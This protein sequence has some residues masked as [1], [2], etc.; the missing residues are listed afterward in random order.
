MSKKY[1]DLSLILTVCFPQA[2]LSIS[3][4]KIYVLEILDLGIFFS[5][6]LFDT[7]LIANSF[8]FIVK[9]FFFHSILIM[10]LQSKFKN[11][12]KENK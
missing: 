10:L 7:I 5:I 1:L 3:K 2:V 9:V 4:T 11:S 12:N 8:F 6:L